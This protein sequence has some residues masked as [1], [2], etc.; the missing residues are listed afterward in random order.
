MKPEKPKTAN[1][2]ETEP[3]PTVNTVPM[4]LFGVLFVLLCTGAIYF[5]A[6]GGW[7]DARVYQPYVRPP[8]DF[9]PRDPGG[10]NLGAGKRVY[11]MACAVCHM[12]SGLGNPGVHAPPIAGSEWVL[13][14]G[15]N[16][17]IRIVLHGLQGPIEV[18]G[19]QY[20]A[21]VMTPFK[22]V[23]SDQDIAAVL[24][25]I[26]MNPEWKHK[27]TPVTPAQVAK[28]RDLTKDRGSVNWTAAE[29]LQIPESD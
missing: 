2:A 11:D 14:P 8:E 3:A 29:L 26:R 6:R 24:T 19:K 20:G 22:D 1:T 21:G 5:D 23:L 25:F 27:A 17:L 28:V 13:A 10:E 18:A 16:R 15:P 12:P 4:W 9:Q 7:F